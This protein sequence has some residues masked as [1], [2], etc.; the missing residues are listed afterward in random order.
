MAVSLQQ[1]PSRLIPDCFAVWQPRRLELM[2]K[3]QNKVSSFGSALQRVSGTY[4]PIH[5]ICGM[6]QLVFSNLAETVYN[7]CALLHVFTQHT[8]EY[9]N[10]LICTS[11]S[12]HVSTSSQT[13]TV[14]VFIVSWEYCPLSMERAP[15]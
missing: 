5:S 14:H 1:F 4:A 7:Q 15:P 6:S 8:F 11:H 10:N 13:H 12:Q 3:I 2:K 9:V